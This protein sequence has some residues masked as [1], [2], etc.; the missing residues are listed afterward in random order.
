MQ[1]VIDTRV[2]CNIGG[3][4][5]NVLAYADDIVLLEPSWI[6]MQTLLDILDISIR[7]I[8]IMC[9]TSKTV[10][11]VFKPDCRSKVI[12]DKFSAFLLSGQY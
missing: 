7:K 10:C 11:M 1:T 3:V 12:C 2:G 5:M 6:A 8:D 9:S 4:M